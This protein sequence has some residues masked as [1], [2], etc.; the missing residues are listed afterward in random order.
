MRQAWLQFVAPGP[1]AG[2]IRP[3]MAQGLSIACHVRQAIDIARGESPVSR[4]AG[5]VS[6][7]H[8]AALP[9]PQP[10]RALSP[11]AA[12]ARRRPAQAGLPGPVNPEMENL[13]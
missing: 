13:R 9:R 7:G 1:T 11:G 10:H 8:E 4:L 12:T 2:A 6:P 3:P 5:P